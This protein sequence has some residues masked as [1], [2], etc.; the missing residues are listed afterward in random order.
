[1]IGVI[2]WIVGMILT[3]KAVFEIAFYD[4]ALWK[5]IITIIILVATSWVGLIVYYL[6][7]K[8]RM[9]NWLK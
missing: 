2:I 7:A 6:F 8:G 9:E 5:R 4:V 3:I 1:M